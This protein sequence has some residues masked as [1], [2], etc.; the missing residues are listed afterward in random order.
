VMSRSGGHLIGEVGA[1][2]SGRGVD[3]ATPSVMIY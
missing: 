2:L 1:A 3:G